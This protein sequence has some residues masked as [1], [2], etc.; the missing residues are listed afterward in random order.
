MIKS[1]QPTM[2]P[3]PDVLHCHDASP[4]KA[5]A[6]STQMWSGAR[7]GNKRFETSGSEP[8]SSIIRSLMG[9][10]CLGDMTPFVAEDRRA[11]RW[12][13]RQAGRENFSNAANVEVLER[14]SS[15]TALVS[16]RDPTRCSYGWQMWRRGVS[17]R[18]GTCALSGNEIR[19]GDRVYQP[20]MHPRPA[21]ASAMI[22]AAHIESARLP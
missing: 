5:E 17:R 3:T 19:P 2:A 7:A 20:R 10:K 1:V 6:P 21:N 13:P 8:W 15:S 22:L 4:T 9:G 14:I 11:P 18:L 12:A 16:W